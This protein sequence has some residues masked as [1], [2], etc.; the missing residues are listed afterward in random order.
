[1][2][3]SVKNLEKTR[4]REKQ[5]N[6]ISFED[7][8]LF[9]LSLG[10]FENFIDGI[11]I[12][13]EPGKLIY[14]NA[15]AQRICKQM[16]QEISLSNSVPKKNWS[17][18]QSLI[19]GYISFS[20]QKTVIDSEISTGKQGTFRIRSQWLRLEKTDHFYLVVILEDRYQSLQNMVNTNIQEYGLTPREAEVWLLFQ[21]N[22]TYKEIADRLYI[23]L[24]TVKKHM[25]NIYAKL[26]S[27]GEKLVDD[28]CWV[29]QWWAK[30][31][32]LS[33]VDIATIAKGD[34]KK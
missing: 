5:A 13:T 16:V 28:I 30:I 25:K 9:Y 2:Y 27:S 21:T 32:S 1:M 19:D 17:V 34:P 23:T 4:I 31:K 15:C 22:H 26:K 7:S 24:N 18:C 3:S 8:N 20:K 33:S 12:F 6:S 14:A 10:V 11:L 29:W